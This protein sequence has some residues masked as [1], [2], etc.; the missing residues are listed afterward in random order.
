[1]W[2][3]YNTF[4][5]ILVFVCFHVT[6]TRIYIQNNENV[7]I[8]TQ[9]TREKNTNVCSWQWVKVSWHIFSK[10][11]WE[12]FQVFTCFN[13]QNWCRTQLPSKI[14]KL[15]KQ[16]CRLVLGFH[17]ICLASFQNNQLYTTLKINQSSCDIQCELMEVD[18]WWWHNWHTWTRL[19]Y[20]P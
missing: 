5:L 19:C 1:M 18:S 3:K 20:W 8:K 4:L 14:H 9:T 12:K 6:E 7:K 16:L 2:L 10:K 11:V 13:R 15:Y 17:A